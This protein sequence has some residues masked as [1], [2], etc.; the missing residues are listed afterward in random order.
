MVCA[1]PESVYPW[2][3]CVSVCLSALPHPFWV[4]RLV[5]ATPDRR[6]GNLQIPFRNP[7][8]A[9]GFSSF[10]SIGLPL[11]WPSQKLDIRQRAFNLPKE[12]PLWVQ[13][14]A[15]APRQG[16]HC[17]SCPCPK[18]RSCFSALAAGLRWNICL[19]TAPLG[20]CM[21]SD[22]QAPQR[23][24]TLPCRRPRHLPFQAGV[25][26]E[27]SAGPGA[28]PSLCVVEKYQVV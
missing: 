9:V 24:C 2:P 4:Y 1:P 20:S 25:C 22:G 7:T 17:H 28:K 18:E 14:P 10:I 8:H 23:T 16:P 13:T 19:G 12:A 11:L 15:C 26:R 3:S 6:A 5:T 27:D 21:C